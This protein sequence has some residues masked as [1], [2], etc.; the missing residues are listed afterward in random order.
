MTSVRPISAAVAA[1]V[2]DR[3]ARTKQLRRS[4]LKRSR[5]PLHCTVLRE[6]TAFSGR[7][8]IHNISLDYL[9]SQVIKRNV[10]YAGS[11]G[12]EVS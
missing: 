2:V 7:S 9:V 3:V 1:T 6:L 8:S 10:M 5:R 11:C 4:S 12:A